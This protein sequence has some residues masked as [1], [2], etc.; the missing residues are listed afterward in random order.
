MEH[1]KT[2]SFMN[3][4]HDLIKKQKTLEGNPYIPNALETKEMI[5]QLEYTPQPADKEFVE[6]KKKEIE[7]LLRKGREKHEQRVAAVF[8]QQRI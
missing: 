3:T 1:I 5:K 8:E 6:Q 7:M 2:S 4:P